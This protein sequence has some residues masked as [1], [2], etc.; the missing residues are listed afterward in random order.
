VPALDHADGDAWKELRP[1]LGHTDETIREFRSYGSHL[2]SLFACVL[3]PFSQRVRDGTLLSSI[4]IG[5]CYK[6]GQGQ[7]SSCCDR[8]HPS[9]R[10]SNQLKPPIGVSSEPESGLRGTVTVLN[11]HDSMRYFSSPDLIDRR[12]THERVPRTT[13]M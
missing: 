9:L 10:A 6:T 8:A 11:K 7:L 12:E 5:T 2:S 1:D 3:I 13:F 4:R